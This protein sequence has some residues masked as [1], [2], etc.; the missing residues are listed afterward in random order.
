LLQ[1]LHTVPP[2]IGVPQTQHVFASR[3]IHSRMILLP[4]WIDSVKFD[5]AIYPIVRTRYAF[6]SRGWNDQRE[7]SA[8][9]R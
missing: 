6:T 2:L 3:M 5:Q 1:S 4:L 7:C 9:T 8:H